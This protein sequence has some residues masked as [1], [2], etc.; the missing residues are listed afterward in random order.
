VD[1]LV[2][3]ATGRALAQVLTGDSATVLMGVS[4]AVLLAFVLMN[5]HVTGVVVIGLGL[6][7]N[8]VVVVVNIGMPVRGS[9]LVAADIVTRNE[10]ATTELVGPRHLETEHDRLAVLGDVLPMPIGGEVLSFGDLI[11]VAGAADA[12]REL[13]RRRRRAW[14]AEERLTYES[15]ATQLRAVQDW[16]VA[17][18]GEPDSGSQNSEKPDL[19]V[20]ETID[21]TSPP[22]SPPARPLVAATHRR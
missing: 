6:L 5:A 18:S 21:L 13:A 15:M 10:L 22:A 1:L 19:R 4:L 17:P 11:I 14:T 7:L 12:V 3:G 2:A 9:A 16:G 8:L 20:P